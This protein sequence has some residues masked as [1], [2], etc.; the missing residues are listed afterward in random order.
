MLGIAVGPASVQDRDGGPP[1]V[2]ATRKLY[3]WI[4]LLF[5]DGGYAGPKFADAVNLP[6]LTIEVV[7]RSD[8]T[9]GFTVLP[10]RWVVERTI[11]WLTRCRRM[12]RHYEAL[13]A[14]AE[15]FVKLAMIRILLRRLARDAAK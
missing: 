5:V 15:A 1:L 8:D 6:R 10:R 7:K 9:K 4:E 2:R 13:A 3:H 12:A 14:L 11:G